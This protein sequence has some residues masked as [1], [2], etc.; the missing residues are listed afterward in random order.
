MR[1]RGLEDAAWRTINS[2]RAW[3]ADP[4]LPLCSR[5][6]YRRVEGGWSWERQPEKRPVHRRRRQGTEA[7][8]QERVLETL[9]RL[10]MCE[11]GAS[12]HTSHG[13][14]DTPCHHVGQVGRGAPL[15]LPSG[16]DGLHRENPDAGRWTG[17][18]RS[19]RRN[20][21]SSAWTGC[22]RW[23]VRHRG[24]SRASWKKFQPLHF[25]ARL[26]LASGP[27]GRRPRADK[28]ANPKHISSKA[29]TLKA[30]HA[31]QAVQATPCRRHCH[32]SANIRQGHSWPWPLP[33]NQT[34]NGRKNI[35]WRAKGMGKGYS[36]GRSIKR[37]WETTH[38]DINDH[39]AKTSGKSTAGNSTSSLSKRTAMYHDVCIARYSIDFIPKSGMKAPGQRRPS[40]SHS[41][42]RSNH[43][44]SASCIPANPRMVV[45]LTLVAK[46]LLL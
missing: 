38:G 21:E 2:S 3:F 9:V 36:I 30:G 5:Q 16:C 39:T 45:L 20:S 17:S 14:L 8:L 15:T 4:D 31:A 37:G 7:Q 43:P 12:L 33:E 44:W 41:Q 1:R 40:A 42:P 11:R 27:K 6:C 28:W 29:S 19:Q 25:H 23:L 18:L 34:G 22:N 26:I 32:F 10:A 24:K 35:L 46:P 13:M